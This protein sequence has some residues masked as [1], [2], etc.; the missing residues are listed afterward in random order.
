MA[1]LVITFDRYR[2]CLAGWE[3]ISFLGN[4][5][6]SVQSSISNLILELV[7]IY[8]KN[9][10]KIVYTPVYGDGFKDYVICMI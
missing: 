3:G 4:K 2:I 6:G 1:L 5:E 9:M 8:N 7:K 10:R